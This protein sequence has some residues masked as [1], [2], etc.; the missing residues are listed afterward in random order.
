M[1]LGAQRGDVLRMVLRHGLA[2]VT[3]GLATGLL[4]SFGLTRFLASQIWGV[5]PTDP[6]TLAFG[7]TKSGALQTRAGSRIIGNEGAANA[8]TE[9]Y[10]VWKWRSRSAIPRG[11]ES[12][13]SFLT[14]NTTWRNGRTRSVKR[15]TEGC[16]Y[17]N[18]NTNSITLE[19]RVLHEEKSGKSKRKTKR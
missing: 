3:A 1:A 19:S 10:P 18:R 14:R 11:L 4:A 8:L 13:C 7:G 2:L 9:D 17:K 5:S 16:P 12:R 6:W 15:R